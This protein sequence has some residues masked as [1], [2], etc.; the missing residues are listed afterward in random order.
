MKNRPMI[1]MAIGLLAVLLLSGGFAVIRS[2]ATRRLPAAPTPAPKFQFVRVQPGT[3]LMSDPGDTT[4][5]QHAVTLTKA[6]DLAAYPVTANQ[7]RAFVAATNYRTRPEITGV[8]AVQRPQL[9]ERFDMARGVSWRTMSAG[10]PGTCPVTCVSWV[11]ATAYCAWASD[12]TGRHVRLPTE[13]EW[14]YA[15]RAG[16]TGDFNVDGVAATDLGWF[17]DNSGD[18]PFGSLPLG[19]SDPGAYYRRVKDEHCRP[20]PVG[21]KRPNAWG[22]YDMHGNVWELCSDATGPYPDGPVT[23]PTGSADDHAKFRRGRGGSFCDP[24]YIGSSFNRGWW[25]VDVGF[26]HIGVRVAADVP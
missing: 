13:A 17:A 15:C 7:F 9:G 26:F 19:R 23:D 5:P 8:A 6:F 20:H 24:P 22:L 18:H 4:D 16:T 12:A 25:P 3:F 11:D 10:Q 1:A 21:Q 14:E 2:V